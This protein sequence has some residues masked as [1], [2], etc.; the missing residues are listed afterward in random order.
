MSARKKAG[1][2]SDAHKQALAVGRQE[3]RAVRAYLEALRQNKPKR[4]RRR[5]PESITKRLKLIDEQIAEADVL[6]RLH[7]HQERIDLMN[8]REMMG[9]ANNLSELE[10]GFIKS[11]KGYGERKRISYAAWRATGVEPVVLS[12][13]G[14]KRK[15]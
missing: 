13:A 9:S 12:K 6:T 15:S 11:A 3:G 7:F 2:M 8:E 10:N 14:I 5:T 4:G 1:P